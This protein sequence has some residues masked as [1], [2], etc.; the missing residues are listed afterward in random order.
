M[1]LDMIDE[2][3]RSI[4]DRVPDIICTIDKN[5]K[6]VWINRASC[7]ILGYGP[8]ELIG[9]EF[10]TLV[11]EEDRPKT[12]QVANAIMAGAEVTNFENR[13]IRK[14]G[15]LV[16]IVWSATWENQSQTMHCIALDATEKKRA[17]ERLR[18]SEQRFKA[19]VQEGSDLI[20]ILG[21]DATYKCVSPT[22]SQILGM[23]PEGFIGKNAFEFIHPEDQETVMTSFLKMETEKIVHIT[24]FRFRHANGTWRWVETVVTNMTDDPSIEGI[25][26][27]S[28]DVTERLEADLRLRESEKR[29]R[30]LFENNPAPMFILDLASLCITDCN[31]SAM[32]LYG[33][34]KEEFRRLTIGDLTLS[35]KEREKGTGA[36]DGD[37]ENIQKQTWRHRK[38]GG[39]TVIVEVSGYAME[40]GGRKS[41]LIMV[42]DITG[43]ESAL[44]LLRENQA[45]LANAQEIA[46]LGYWELELSSKTLYWTDEAYRIWERQRKDFELTPE[47]L[48]ETVHPEDWAVFME[49]QR[50]AL[51]GDSEH[52]LNVRIL[53]PDGTTKWVRIIGKGQDKKDGRYRA[54]AGT[55]QDITQQKT[56]SLS[57]ELAN[58]RYTYVTRASSQA[59]WDWDMSSNA[60]YWGEGFQLSM[61]YGEDETEPD[62]SFWL[63][64]IH[65]DDLERVN[66]SIQEAIAGRDAIW[67]DEYWFLKKDGTYAYIMDKGFVIRDDRGKAMRMV[68]AMQDVTQSKHEESQKLLNAEI[69][70]IFNQ[71]L[72]FGETMNRVLEAIVLSGNY[73]SAEA[74]LVDPEMECLHLI[75]Q[76][77]RFTNGNADSK[78]R[79]FGKCLRGQG[80]P[81]QVWES[82]KTVRWSSEE[83][84]QKPGQ[85]YRTS[86]AGPKNQYGIPL[87]DN[88]SLLGVLVV[89]G[90][91]DRDSRHEFI[92]VT[93]SVGTYLGGEIKR[94][95]LEQELSQIV[96][97]AQHIICVLDLEGTFRKVNPATC[98]IL[99]YSEEELVNRSFISFIH[100]D[101]TGQI[102]QSMQNAR[103][104]GSDF[105]F[106]T[107]AVT[108]S[109]KVRWLSWTMTVSQGERSVFVI[110]KD[111][112]DQRNL[113]DLL[114][115]ANSLARIGGWEF[116]LIN[117]AVFWSSITREI[118]E[119]GPDYTLDMETMLQSHIAGWNRQFV[120]K[121]LRGDFMPNEKWDT[122]LMIITAKG[123]EKWVRMIG[124]AEV[125]N[126]TCTRVFGSFQDIHES[127]STELRL[128][129]VSNNIPGVLFQ[130]HLSPDGTDRLQ[131]VSDG[132]R[133]IWGISPEECASNINL[134]WAQIRAGGD[135]ETVRQTI[136]ESART[137][138]QWHCQWKIIHPDGSPRWHEGYGS[139]HLLS[140]GSIIWDSIVMDITEKKQL[141]NLLDSSSQMARIGS[142]EYNVHRGRYST[143]YWS[144]MVRKILEIGPECPMSDLNA[145][146]FI[147]EDSVGVIRK[148]IRRLVTT[149]ESFDEEV[150]LV[151]AMG[152]LRWARCIGMIEHI[153]SA[154]F[155][156]YGSC[157]DIH[158][159]KLG[160]IRLK[161]LNEDL[162]R[163]AREL[164]LSNAE[165]EQFAYVASHDLQEPLRMVTSFLTQ[166]DK[167][168][169]NAL[170]DKAR[171]YI[172][173]AV[174]GA[175]RMRQIILDLLEFSRI[176]KHDD[177]L[178]AIPLDQ[179]MDEV[180]HL[181]GK[182]IRETRAKLHYANLPTI[183][184]YH[185]PILQVLQNL[186]GNALK[187]RRPGISP[188]IV[189]RVEAESD[190]WRI[191]VADNGI[192][193]DQEYFEKIF[194]IFQRLH[195]QEDYGGTGMGLAIVKKIIENLGGTI[196]LESTVGAGST[197]YLEIPKI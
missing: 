27:N 64:R 150:L 169:G 78:A 87:F 63:N 119:V 152:N 185:S 123:K 196:W 100:P 62:L 49:K 4:V 45:K 139:P 167:K 20:G 107:R 179:I 67:R 105:Y 161:S 26:A 157:Q 30:L 124:E 158:Q 163:Q 93:G 41:T 106:E 184:S 29:Y 99:E 194:I 130:Y 133:E 38:K 16:P 181:Q 22:S 109:G 141:E 50:D 174:D 8:E 47:L 127:K 88:E 151:T 42:N 61:G 120:S 170:D 35:E 32:I 83:F 116:N 7:R 145:N 143:S 14:D 58:H 138:S 48:L 97:H 122:E 36:N 175:R 81:G 2:G 75:G 56:L 15:S 72:D 82:G 193:I 85:G 40:Q 73:L 121:M 195:S 86:P 54:L 60:I 102:S 173:F 144:P 103:D 34:T 55:V 154:T 191:A 172:H 94:K 182:L 115:R 188:E 187:Y 113:K 23:D 43:K 76:H 90:S 77:S 177:E 92:G 24:P 131:Y 108:K 18:M 1:V 183:R 148:A 84:A 192:G 125:I 10:M 95:K 44:N 118:F 59:I 129:S 68:G 159:H 189:V 51:K 33:Y 197:F 178:K 9:S 57:L 156:M 117:G 135:M 171:R 168:Y 6:F 96:N 52:S 160:E 80:L 101:D 70:R 180:C 39:E 25:V 111:I 104:K 137:L 13:Y 69:S 74:W 147:H 5:G 79:V 37:Y 3:L 17:E 126:G 146:A 136:M 71:S 149:G 140:D 142:W 89:E 112:T 66:R 162:V 46:K 110:A 12:M 19:L 98:A 65:P 21:P 11:H 164:A 134:V 114:A 132:V 53:I 128:R 153:N 155:R 176:G 91:S 31:E 190:K 165:L 166:L 186:I 28:R